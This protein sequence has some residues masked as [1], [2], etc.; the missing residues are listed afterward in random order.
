VR[1]A[2]MG[3][4]GIE[5]LNFLHCVSDRVSSDYVVDGYSTINK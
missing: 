5:S 1:T 3:A 2:S 4:D